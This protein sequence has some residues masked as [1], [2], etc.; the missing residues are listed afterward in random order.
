MRITVTARHV[1]VDEALRAHAVE[2]VTR[3]AKFAR[4]PHH[5]QVVF[6]ADHDESGVEL[7]LHVPRGRVHVAKAFGPDHRSAL[8]VAI[9]RLKRQLIDEKTSPR[10]RR[11]RIPRAT[12]PKVPEKQ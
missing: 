1:D 10:P 7:E 3:V 5:A 9:D 4:R 2:L 12:R 6:L 11:A 8:D